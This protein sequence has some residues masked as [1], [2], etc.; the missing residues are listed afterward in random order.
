MYILP[1]DRHVI[2]QVLQT[3]RFSSLHRRLRRHRQHH[4]YHQYSDP[5][6]G[7][8]YHD[9]DLYPSASALPVKSARDSESVVF[10]IQE[11]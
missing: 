2:V 7:R 6:S 11:T 1:F 3:H 8:Y 4:H 5:E 10:C 9:P